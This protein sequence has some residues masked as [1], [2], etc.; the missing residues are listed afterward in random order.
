MVRLQPPRMLRISMPKTSLSRSV[1]SWLSYTRA[2]RTVVVPVGRT[3]YTDRGD[4]RSI[5]GVSII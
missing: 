2:V 3:G 4:R 1:I 5:R